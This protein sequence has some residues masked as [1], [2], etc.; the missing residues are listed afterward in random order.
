MRTVEEVLSDSR[1]CINTQVPDRLF[2]S[3]VKSYRVKEVRLEALLCF[4]GEGVMRIEDTPMYKFLNG[5]IVGY[6]SYKNYCIKYPSSFRNQSSFNELQSQLETTEYDIKKGA[7]V[8]N[9]HN[10][11]VDGQHRI[12]ILL[13][14]YGPKHR[15]KVVEICYADGL[16]GMRLLVLRFKLIQNV[17]FLLLKCSVLQ[18]VFM[19]YVHRKTGGEIRSYILRE[20]YKR[21]YGIDAG[22]YTY[23][24]FTPGFNFGGNKV[25]I[26]RYC[27]IAQGVCFLGANH[28]IDQFST[29]AVFYNSALGL[30]VKDIKRYNLI[31]EDDVWIGLNAT[32]TCGCTRIGRGAIIGAGSVVTKDIEP[33]TIVA[34]NPAR[35]IR[36]R[37]DDTRI[38]QLES[39]KWWEKSP[40]QLLIDFKEEV[41]GR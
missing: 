15:I 39:S 41:Y 40:S 11:I 24:C 37:F 35:V 3:K 4:Y 34:G 21:K 26:G 7:I 38:R 29:S 9:Q 14:K 2:K 12:S 19:S 36:K 6:D 16:L 18:K 30:D 25:I 8:V 17:V 33:Y 5:D 1:F 27:S 13:K 20:I 22:Y 10:I 23:G 32:I 28:P 31:I